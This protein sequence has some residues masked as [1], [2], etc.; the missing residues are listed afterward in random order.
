MLLAATVSAQ[1]PLSGIDAGRQP[2]PK[3]P[4][5]ITISRIHPDNKDT[6]TLAL[7][8][9]MDKHIHIY[10]TQSLFFKLAVNKKQGLG[11][12]RIELPKPKRLVNFD[13]SVVNVFVN[14]QTIVIKHPIITP[15]WSLTGVFVSQ[16]CDSLMCFTPRTI[17]FT[18][19]SEGKLAAETEA[20]AASSL[21]MVPPAPFGDAMQFLDKFTVVGS[22]SGFLKVNRFSDFLNN[23]GKQMSNTG[24]FE[25]KGLWLVILLIILGGIALNLTPCVLPMI[26]VTVA[27]IG[28]G[29]QAKSGK[30]GMLVGAVYGLSMALTYGILGLLVVL[31]GARFGV[32]NA[33]P[34][35]N[36]AIAVIFV[37]MAFGMFDIIQVDFTRFR[38]AGSLPSER[39]KIFAVFFMGIVAS[40]LA[41]ACVAPVVISVVLYAGTLYAKGN[42]VGLL[43]PFLL[44]VGMALPWPFAG[45]GLSF[46]PKPGKWMVW[47][48][49]VFGV[50]ILGMALYYGYLGMSLF[51]EQ[52]AGKAAGP[53][54]A[55]Q[56]SPTDLPWHHSLVK[57]LEKAEVENKPVFIDFWATWC[58]NCKAMNAS[59]FRDPGVKTLLT[60]YVLVKYQAEKPDDPATK[61][62]L[63]HFGVVGLPTYV[64]LAPK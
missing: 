18:A 6:L 26:P 38:K 57:G 14:G 59:T 45:A 54:E 19:T 27:I 11:Q 44:G 28:A 21:S 46:L 62:I 20:P 52:T 58:K 32:I 42:P 61:R 37:L 25:N 22:A 1:V 40:L 50:F 53:A 8:L 49:Y 36:I 64:I 10:S 55:A 16:A 63:D 4:L 7:T 48:K 31:T 39:G 47:V 23:P 35:F 30:R 51:R 9:R 34:L 15:D 24:G 60:K 13:K 56:L 29:A 33:S 43:L 5:S 12:T 2:P 17:N 3:D 41:G